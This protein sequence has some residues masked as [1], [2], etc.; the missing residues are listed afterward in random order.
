MVMPA[1]TRY[2]WEQ[3]KETICV[4]DELVILWIVLFF[5]RA[6][7]SKNQARRFRNLHVYSRTSPVNAGKTEE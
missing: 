6:K 2:P 3:F 4:P 1:L 5:A 7:Q